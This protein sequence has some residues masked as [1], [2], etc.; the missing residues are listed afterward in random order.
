MSDRYR[1]PERVRRSSAR[2]RDYRPTGRATLGPSSST[3]ALTVKLL[4]L[5]AI[6]SLLIA[7]LIAAQMASGNDPALGPKAVAAKKGTAKQSGGSSSS[8]SSNGS[9]SDPYGESNDG[10]GYYYGHGGS[11][12]YTGSSGSSGYGSSSSG[13]SGYSYTPPP[14]T[15]STS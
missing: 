8:S 12:G 11:D 9:G 13:S 1:R 2:P 4:I 3:S 5:A 10:Y 6:G 15:S 7:G 14:V